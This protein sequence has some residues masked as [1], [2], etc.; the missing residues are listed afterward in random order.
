MRRLIL[1]VD[2]VLWR[3]VVVVVLQTKM[4]SRRPRLWL[5]L[6]QVERWVFMVNNTTRVKTGCPVNIP[7]SPRYLGGM[8]D[9]SWSVKKTWCSTDLLGDFS[10]A[11]GLSAAASSK[12]A[13]RARCTKQAVAESHA[14]ETSTALP[15]HRPLHQAMAQSTS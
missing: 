14:R 5:W 2:C 12:Q 11:Q 6:R 3:G 10:T 7:L 8:C 1:P 13:L 15:D 4:A 9:S